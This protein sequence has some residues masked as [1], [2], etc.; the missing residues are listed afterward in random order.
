MTSKL[1]CSPSEIIN[2]LPNL[3]RDDLL[4]IQAEISLLLSTPDNSEQ[5]EASPKESKVDIE[6]GGYIELKEINGYGPYAY[7]RWRD[8]NVLRSRYLGKVKAT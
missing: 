4:T 6:K 5:G 3:S 7:L 1:C 2:S 8:G